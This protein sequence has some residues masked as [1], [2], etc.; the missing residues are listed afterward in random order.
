MAQ[1]T[2]KELA[3]HYM[4]LSDDMKMRQPNLLKYYEE[5]KDEI[6]KEVTDDV[7]EDI[8]KKKVNRG[9]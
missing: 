4:N 1:E 5:F 3:I 9:K 7:E 8:S 2:R 6:S